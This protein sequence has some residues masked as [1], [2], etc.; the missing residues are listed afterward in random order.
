[1]M[2]ESFNFLASGMKIKQNY[3]HCLKHKK[4]Y[5]ELHVRNVIARIEANSFL[6]TTKKFNLK[7]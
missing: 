2:N 1:M 4:Q 3:K 6:V 5:N 7:N